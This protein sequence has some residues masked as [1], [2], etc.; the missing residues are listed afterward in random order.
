AETRFPDRLRA[1]L[2]VHRRLSPTEAPL[3]CRGQ[4]RF[5]SAL[6]A[7]IGCSA[8]GSSLSESARVSSSSSVK[9]G[10]SGLSSSSVAVASAG[11]A[12]SDVLLR[13]YVL[14]GPLPTRETIS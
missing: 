8:P 5:V 2:G 10:C 1:L 13:L 3:A 6:R 12:S 11:S 14:P 9:L 7:L 4:R